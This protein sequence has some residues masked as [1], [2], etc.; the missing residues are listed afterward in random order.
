MNK[1]LLLLALAVL[2]GCRQPVPPQLDFD[3]T[4]FEVTRSD[5]LGLSVEHPARY[6]ATLDGNSLIL[7]DGGLTAVRLTLATRAEARNRGL[8]A[9]ADPVGDTGFGGT[10]G[11]WYRYRHWDGPSW[12]PT[13]AYVV[14]HRGLELGVEFR[15]TAHEFDAVHRH[16]LASLELSDEA[17]AGQN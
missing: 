14:P 11:T 6:R 5:E 4:R 12:V 8:W 2:A 15:T 16:I 9:Q 17:P 13:L 10:R 1:Y 3:Q 7:S